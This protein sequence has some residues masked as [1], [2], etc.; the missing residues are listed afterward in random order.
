MI[1]YFL[2]SLR[3]HEN[4]LSLG[5][6]TLIEKINVLKQ[7]ISKSKTVFQKGPRNH[8]SRLHHSESKEQTD[9][10]S[11]VP[12]HPMTL[13]QTSMTKTCHSCGWHGVGLSEF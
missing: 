5:K 3:T 12:F 11:K 6:R 9:D 10:C 1:K 7:R 4:N 13:K 8:L 2:P